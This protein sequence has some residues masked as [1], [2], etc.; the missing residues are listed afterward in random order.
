MTL[1]P[2]SPPSQTPATP[3]ST[4]QAAPFQAQAQLSRRFAELY[5]GP[6]LGPLSM[7]FDPK[8]RR[9]VLDA[10]APMSLGQRLWQG[11][12]AARDA[13]AALLSRRTIK[14]MDEVC[15]KARA[16]LST[17]QPVWAA[18]DHHDRLGVWEDLKQSA[19]GQETQAAAQLG[20]LFG[21]PV[22]GALAGLFVA[23]VSASQQRD[24]KVRQADELFHRFI[25][26]WYKHVELALRQQI[27]PPSSVTTWQAPPGAIPTD[28]P[29]SCSL[30][31]ASC[32]SPWGL[33]SA[34]S[35]GHAITRRWCSRIASPWW[36]SPRRRHG[37]RLLRPHP[38]SELPNH[39][40]RPRILQHAWRRRCP[41][42]V[43]TAL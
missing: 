14:L 30:A 16:E 31:A 40:L 1:P 2:G 12:C 5:L 42:P 29:G 28:R 6:H 19:L 21:H 10:C 43:A 36:T 37:R 11:T 17:I 35:R 39:R 9:A 34:F 33:A 24:E 20:D 27:S 41:S 4:L 15:S 8:I 26:G 18:L 13:H 23:A 38:R 3:T 32:C 22:L 25:G 7:K